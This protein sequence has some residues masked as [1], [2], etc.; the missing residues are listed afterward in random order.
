LAISAARLLDA[1]IDQVADDG[2]SRAH[3][4]D[5]GELGG[6]DLDEGRVGQ[7]GQAARDLGLADAGRADHQDVL[8]RDFVA[9]RF[10]HLLAAPAVAQ[11]DGDRLLGLGLADHVLVEFADDFL[12]SHVH[13]GSS[14]SMM[15][16]RLV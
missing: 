8:G 9:Q 15:W 13:A 1:D 11:G 6:F 14:V 4:A 5:F 16:F 7:L 2:V 12:R 10:G 3:V